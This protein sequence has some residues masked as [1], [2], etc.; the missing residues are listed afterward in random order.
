M[1][2]REMYI[3]GFGHFHDYTLR[4]LPPGL[5][6]ISGPNEAGKSTMLA[7]I[8]RMLFGR[9]PGRSFNPYEPLN[10]GEYG[11]RLTVETGEGEVFDIV[12]QGKA[13]R[14]AVH[15]AK[16]APVGRPLTSITGSADKYFYD[17]VFA[18]GLEELYRFETLS[19]ESVQNHVTG[20]GVGMKTCSVPDLQKTMKGE[21]HALYKP[22]RSSKPRITMCMKE[23]AD[24]EKEIRALSKSQ[25]RYDEC[26]RD[27]RT[28]EA[29]ISRFKA[30]KADIRKETEHWKRI[31]GIWEDWTAYQDIS[32]RLGALPLIESF[33]E[34]GIHQLERINERIQERED[35][36]T[37]KE[38]ERQQVLEDS[39]HV[40]VNAAVLDHASGIR[41]LERGL[42]KY[43]SD[44]S[45]C[46]ALT[47]ERAN[48]EDD[49]QRTLSGLNLDWDD[50]ALLSF[51]TSPEAQGRVAG[52]RRDFARYEEDLRMLAKE[53]EQ[54]KSD[55]DA[56]VPRCRVLR[57]TLRRSEG[58][59]AEEQ[60]LR[61]KKAVD[62]L[63]AEI[64]A[65]DR[66]KADLDRAEKEEAAAGERWREAQA[67]LAGT[68]PLWPAVLMV[69]AGIVS[70]GVG[71][72]GDSLLIGGGLL[73]LFLIAAGVYWSAVQKHEARRRD[74]YADDSVNTSKTAVLEWA[75]LRRNKQEEVQVLSSRLAGEAEVAGFDTIPSAATIAGRRD[76]LERLSTAIAERAN[77][78]TEL[79]RLEEELAGRNL[80]LEKKQ[81]EHARTEEG[82]S[83]LHAEWTAWLRSASLPEGMLPDIVQGI[84][85]KAE[86]LV[87]LY[88]SN[89]AR[90][91]DRQTLTASVEAYGSQLTTLVQ[92]CGV[93]AV[94]SVEGDLESLVSSLAENREHRQMLESA[95]LSC[96]KL[97]GEIAQL[98][99][100]LEGLLGEKT[101]L[102]AKGSSTDEDRFRENGRVWN[103]QRELTRALE[104][105]RSA[106]AR[107]AG[108]ETPFDAFTTEL[109]RLD[110]P[111]VAG[112]IADLE[113]RLAETE[114]KIEEQN[115]SLGQT[116]EAIL[117]LETGDE[118]AAL[119]G[120]HRALCEDA[121]DASREWAKRVIAAHILGKAVERYEKERQPAVIREATEIFS[122][123]S[124]GRYRRIIKPLDGADVLV[125]E[126]TGGRKE[127]R[128]LS[129]GTAEQLYL[130]LRFGYITEFGKHDVALP[131]VFDDILVN[132]DPVRKEN[133]CRA[134]ARLAETNQVLYFTCHPDTVAMLERC[135]GDLRVISLE[136]AIR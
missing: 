2:I 54:H 72:V 36:R 118:S 47:K 26:Q 17:N 53:V 21:M 117:Q 93:S 48:A 45:S 98:T 106:I 14:Y 51:D 35:V 110:L 4:D 123:I 31:A 66:L 105:H 136:D 129:R 99:R 103:E 135:C 77:H 109:E 108:R 28:G 61:E 86:Q 74:R 67:A 116:K 81:A 113:E 63:Y 78:R 120:R 3:D 16:G 27:R 49:Y 104:T 1:K 38:R 87:A 79:A 5:T 64:P 84:F 6:V 115:T 58:L 134:I 46:N 73:V 126:A 52:F 11:G 56:G 25:G 69:A 82:L 111:E 39:S 92:A 57:E 7:F 34:E 125:E 32:D 13:D 90:S 75:D 88:H 100:D 122:D 42:E 23:I 131:V 19:E 55:R 24:I 112:T 22:G 91:D 33:P 65:L 15:D 41:S 18:F 43:L 68:M 50:A 76:E 20:A 95:E 97:E 8:R 40:T 89:R 124:G 132:F 59:P 9:P 85:P 37:Q 133:S 10:G 107:A 30:L 114:E 102:L 130:A 101:A 60:V 62:V 119:E 94:G 127:V 80:W 121:N 29:E 44:V 71:A 96:R 70:L 83:K 128:E 12:R